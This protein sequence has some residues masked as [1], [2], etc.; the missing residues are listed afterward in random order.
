MILTQPE[1]LNEPSATPVP[2]VSVVIPTYNQAAF[3]EDAI[4]SV[5]AQTYADYEVIVVNDGSTDDTEKVTL[6]YN[7]RI[8]YLR[9]ENQG[10]AGARN[11]GILAAR[12]EFIALLD[13]DDIWDASFLASMMELAR[14]APDA[15]VYYCGIRYI[16][17][18]RRDLPQSG[19]TRVLAPQEL[20]RAIL[21][22]NFLIPSTIVMRRAAIL[23]A[24]LF[25]IA[26]RRLQ[27]RELWIRLLQSGHRFAGLEAQLVRYRVHE[28]NL[29]TD[30]VGGQQALRAMVEKHF[31][32][33]D[34]DFTRWSPEKHWAYGG[35]YRFYLISSIQRQ[36]N[37]QHGVDY[38]RKA[39]FFDPTLA[40]DTNLFYDLALGNQPVGYRGTDH[41]LH[42]EEN[43]EKIQALLE[44]L[45]ASG[46]GTSLQIQRSLIYTN[47][48]KALGLIAYNTNQFALFRKYFWRI[49]RQQPGIWRDRML[50][51]NYLKS[52]LGKRILSAFRNVRKRINE[53]NR[54]VDRLRKAGSG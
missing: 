20:Y 4:Q 1:P 35:L 53:V 27:D 50:V 22:S 54:P 40:E 11:S 37:W 7:H 34:G 52:F 14:K 36:N 12:G 32:N 25:D 16:D 39:L 5:L 26:Y 43:G 51:G 44:A 19:A 29:S 23:E 47:A 21:R 41:H 9:Q 2:T 30:P 45:F 49:V 24:A 8:R 18:D 48:Y 42:L 46:H 13:S 28:N 10:L 6:G 33:E 17:R 31:G 3:L 15:T 38:L